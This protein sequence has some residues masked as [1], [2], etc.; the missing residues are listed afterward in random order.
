MQAGRNAESPKVRLRLR[1]DR[2]TAAARL[3]ESLIAGL[4]Q[5]FTTERG[6][7]PSIAESELVEQAA[8]AILQR[9]ALVAAEARGET[10]DRR[11]FCDLAGTTSRTL[12]QLGIAVDDDHGRLNRNK[13]HR[14]ESAQSL[15]TLAQMLEDRRG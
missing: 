7:A 3:L 11:E 13:R 6:R 14:V 15:P 10:I 12:R 1:V 8:G 5:Q 2:R 9:K 4:T